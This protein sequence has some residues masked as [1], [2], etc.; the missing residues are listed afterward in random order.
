[1]SGNSNSTIPPPKELGEGLANTPEDAIYGELTDDEAPRSI[2][3]DGAGQPSATPASTAPAP[4]R[5]APAPAPVVAPGSTT[6]AATTPTATATPVAVPAPSPVAAPTRAVAHALAPLTTAPVTPVTAPVASTLGATLEQSTGSPHEPSV[7]AATQANVAAPTQANTNVPHLLPALVPTSD[8]EEAGAA[9]AGLNTQGDLVI[10][11]ISEEGVAAVGVRASLRADH[12]VSTDRLDAAQLAPLGDVQQLALLNRIHRLMEFS[13]PDRGIYSMPA[14]PR[15]CVWGAASAFGGGDQSKIL[16]HSNNPAPVVMWL[17]GQITTTWMYDRNGYPAP[18]ATVNIV[19]LSS[20]ARAT[21]AAHL[22]ALSKDAKDGGAAAAWGLEQVRMYTWMNTGAPGKGT[23]GA[24]PPPPEF[25]EFYDATVRLQD[26]ANMDK[27]AIVD[28]KEHDLVMIEC[29]VQRYAL[30]AEQ[31]QSAR[32]QRRAPMDKWV[33]YYNL[34]AVYLLH[35]AALHHQ[36]TI[37]IMQLQSTASISVVKAQLVADNKRASE[38]RIRRVMGQ[39]RGGAAS[40][41]AIV[42]PGAIQGRDM[43]A[44]SVI[45]THRPNISTQENLLAAVNAIVAKEE[46]MLLGRFYDRNNAVTDWYYEVYGCVNEVSTFNPAY[47]N[48]VGDLIID[49]ELKAQS[50]SV[51]DN[52]VIVKNSPATNIVDPV[53]AL[54]ALVKTL[55]WYLASERQRILWTIVDPSIALD[56]LVKTLWWYL[57]SGSR[58]QVVP[59]RLGEICN[60]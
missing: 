35:A 50:I 56:A 55:W 58:L 30:R 39:I 49:H 2:A 25:S 9:G 44:K 1:M 28:L 52:V 45:I 3:T 12:S 8:A 17:I 33:A 53:I 59:T 51:F 29:T 22:N 43:L 42:K 13:D 7:S 4:V 54:D 21:G 38:K 10:A 41:I 40:N 23:G 27:L 32:L 20:T 48:V 18:R 15:Q 6:P 46:V 11:R 19:P 31:Q 37:P 24:P 34:Q 26:K 47:L 60:L 16:C 57:A 36:F 5:P 14:V